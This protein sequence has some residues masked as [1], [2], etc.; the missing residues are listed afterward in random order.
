VHA[1]DD[2]TQILS[3]CSAGDPAAWRRL[4]PF[5]YAELGRLAESYLRNERTGHTLQPTALVH[6]SYIRLVEQRLPRFESRGHFLA[7]AAQVMRQ[8][9]V[10]S[11]RAHRAAKR[12][13]GLRALPIQDAAPVIEGV[14]WGVIELDEALNRLRGRNEA[15]AQVIEYHY[16]GG[17]LVAEIAS[18]TGRSERTIARELRAAKLFLARELGG[19]A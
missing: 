9:L 18:V 15:H 13:G 8:V 4:T 10:D 1:G 5:L 6:E 2:I 16:F 7:L 12:G 11:A 17:L 19:A 14:N 3:A